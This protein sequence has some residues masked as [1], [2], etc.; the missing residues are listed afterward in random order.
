MENAPTRDWKRSLLAILVCWT[1]CCVLASAQDIVTVSECPGKPLPV[2]F[3]VDCSHVADPAMKQQCKPFAENQACKA[4]FAYRTITGISLEQSC[5]VFRYVIYDAD[6]WPH[7]KGEGGLAGRCGADYISDDSI[8]IKSQIGPYDVHEILH[9]Y[10][11]DL[12]AIPYE[13][14]LFAP[15]MAEA[16]RMVGDNKGYWDAM[17]QLKEEMARTSVTLEK[18]SMAPDKQ[19]LSAELSTEANLYLK[20][21]ANL[22]Q[23][24]RKLE[25]SRLK[26]MD[27][28]YRRF[29]RMYNAVSGGTAKQYLLAHCP[30]F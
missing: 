5:P 1:A 24:Y 4:F 14:I 11:A 7:P 9:V 18:G 3:Q 12:G 10:Q 23:M 27:D 6:K 25:R 17:T 30:A 28:R 2:T 13:H 8:G 15:S 19:C 26:D 22:G 20:N 16:R 29:N 21:P